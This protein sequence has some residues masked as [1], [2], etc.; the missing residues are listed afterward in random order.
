MREPRRLVAAEMLERARSGTV[1][2]P[3][4]LKR[5]R[6]SKGVNAHREW[7][8]VSITQCGKF[9]HFQPAPMAAISMASGTSHE[10]SRMSFL[11]EDG[12]CGDAF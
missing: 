3:P 2:G 4:P 5:K 7:A 11:L 9:S 8:F 12:A 1:S 10:R 6:R